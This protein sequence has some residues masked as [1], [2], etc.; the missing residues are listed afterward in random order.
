[1]P[2]ELR[3]TSDIPEAHD[4]AGAEP[5]AVA[6]RPAEG[7]R[8]GP[9][10]YPS[11]S[12]P[13]EGYTL[14]RGVGQGG[15]GEIYYAVSDAGKEVALKLIRRNLEVELRG[16]RVCLNLKHP[17]LLDLY[18]IRQDAHG[19]TWVVMEYVAGACLE[20]VLAAHPAGLPPER[21]LAWIQGIGAGLAYL[22]DRGIVHRDLK[23]GNVF[24]D[25]CLVKIGDYGLSKFIS[26]SRRSGHTESIGTV[27]YIA[28]E[29][30]TGRYGKEIDIYA[31]GVML[32][33][34][35]TGRVPFDG[36]SVGEVLMKH[37]TAQPDVSML[38]EPY[39]SVVAKALE[40]DPRRRFQTVREMLAPLPRVQ[41]TPDSGQDKAPRLRR[42][43]EDREGEGRQDGAQAPES[44]SDGAGHSV[45][46]TQYSATRGPSPPPLPAPPP[47]RWAGAH[48]IR[49]LFPPGEEPIARGVRS[50]LRKLGAAW[51]QQGVGGKILLVIAVFLLSVVLL[52]LSPVLLPVYLFYLFVRML[53]LTPDPGPQAGPAAPPPIVAAARREPAP[54]AAA[55]PQAAPAPPP[56]PVVRSPRERLA[57]LVG[58]LLVGALAALAMSAVMMILAVHGYHISAAVAAGQYA[59][60]ALVGIMGT[61]GLLLLGRFWE[62]HAEEALPR[63][64]ILL[65]FGLGLGLAAWFVA[66]SLL[67]DLP[68]Y[69]ARHAPVS[70]AKPPSSFYADGRAQPI[71]YMAVFGT[72]LGLLRWW[73]QADRLRQ[74]RLHLWPVA[75]SFLAAILVAG[76][77]DFPEMWLMMVSGVMSVSVQ[78]AAPWVPPR[79]RLSPQRKTVV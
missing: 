54:T 65:V 44:G 8:A 18:D 76:M 22:H 14:K 42:G 31:L 38:A 51:A 59:W 66:E 37:L 68:R 49:T 30:A 67:V 56:P 58:S 61:W 29:V 17:N 64:F 10:L 32:Y 24:A 9:F 33:E 77:W 39:R 69:A 23:P 16:I 79:A 74:V 53:V 20:D 72:L 1:M 36:E 47:P 73:R 40:K 7:H 28:P 5:R 3:N 12:R 71:A 52:H 60:V 26:C 46:G 2:P 78:L 27:H 62:G 75:V 55:K 34:M 11:G 63:R 19:D 13:L 15:F 70:P 6:A 21:V 45:P 25:E 4:G 50:L 48:V 41:G 35:L 57:E 43:D